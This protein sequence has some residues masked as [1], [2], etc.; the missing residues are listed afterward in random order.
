MTSVLI[1]GAGPTGLALA[2]WLTRLGI[3]ARIIDKAAEPGTTSRALG[4]QARTLELYRQVG[5]ADDVVAGG[6]EVA[7]VNLWAGGARTAR[8]PFRDLGV[9][10]T[11]FPSFLI[12]PQD[13]HE[14][15]LIERLHALGV[16]VERETELVDLD[17]ERTGARVTLR[18]R[19]GSEQ[20]CEV[21]FVAGCDGADSKVRKAVGIGFPG[22]T[23]SRLFY[24]ADV[25]ASGP[26][27]D[28]ELHVDL[29]EADFVAVFPL[30][31]EGCVRL[32]GTIREEAAAS[33]PALTFGDVSGQVI[34]KLQLAVSRVNWFSTYHVHHR[35]A[36]HFR[37]GRAFLAGDAA[38]IHSPV[39]AQGM[40]TGIGDAVN[41]AWKLA[42]VLQGRAPD[43]LLDTY[44]M[45]RIAFARRLV[46]ST[47]RAFTIAV[48]EGAAAKRVRTSIFPRVAP[49]GVSVPPLR[50]WIFRTVS[51]LGVNYRKSPMSAGRA[52]SV[53][54]GDRLPWVPLSGNEDNFTP[55]TSLRWQVH[56]YGEPP[57]GL[58]G[59]C[60][61]LGVPLHAF[62]R[63]RGD[64]EMRKA[65]L[66]PGALYLVRPDGY[67]ALA[68]PEGSSQRLRDYFAERDL[69]P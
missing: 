46:A 1:V 2:L 20:I 4:V 57:P 48:K 51:Q 41:L 62:P 68:D 58:A 27:T 44:E 35:V 69:R 5:I 37:A 15:F 21:A 36:N 12:Y 63:D 42:A 14:R 64:R 59:A 3:E 9:G 67:V 16:N 45:E 43:R 11:P 49:F 65:G 38:H 26:A 55:L 39:G 28:H 17:Q 19:D 50:R 32:V 13:A 6:V 29:D 61:A 40:N 53:R 54:G 7:G 47:D 60:D 25:E 56:V 18:C 33:D 10:L 22:G 23:Y 24:V 30:K 8:I 34:E 52:G 66:R 31:E